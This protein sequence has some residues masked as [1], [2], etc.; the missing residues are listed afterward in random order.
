MKARKIHTLKVEALEPRYLLSGLWKGVDIDGDSV[1]VKLS[2]RGD[3]DVAAFDSGYGEQIESITVWGANAKSKLTITAS[4]KAGGDGYVDIGAID[5]A[6][7]DLKEIKVDGNLGNMV[8]DSVEKISLY[9]TANLDGSL[10]EWYINSGLKQLT[11]EG[12]LDYADLVVNGN[13]KKVTVEGHVTDASLLVDGELKKME[14]WGD[15]SANSLIDVSETIGTITIDGYLENSTIATNE[16]LNL[17]E[18][19]LDVLDADI[20]G[21]WAIWEIYVDGGMAGTIVETGGFLDWLDVWNWIEESEILAGPEGIGT[22]W[23]YNI[24]DTTIETDGEIDHIYLDAYTPPS[25]DVYIIEE[26]VW[27]WPVYTEVVYVDEYYY[28]DYYY[29]DYYYYTDDYYYDD[30]YYD[31]YYY[32]DYYDSYYDDYYYTD[33]YYTDIYYDPYYT[34]YYYTDSYYSYD[35]WY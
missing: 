22:I 18:V 6:G 1:T 5:A 23:A 14:V 2:G 20:Y 29:D 16:E 8:V 21:Q 3:M 19:G 33:Y 26:D 27:Y 12:N 10:V 34:D 31:D 35:V 4:K 24:S 25:Y 9:S 30:Y 7:E 32:V 28:D 11:L 13:L 15:V 17:L